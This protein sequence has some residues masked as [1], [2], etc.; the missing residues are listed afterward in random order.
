MP[1]HENTNMQEIKVELEAKVGE[2]SYS[3]LVI[4][5]HSDCEFIFDFATFLPGN[6]S[7][8]VHSRIIMTPKHAKLL[9]HSLQQNI[10]RFES[11]YGDIPVQHQESFMGGDGRPIVN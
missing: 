7:A 10:A 6:P 8:R 9:L 1:K 11:Q 5:A 4:I 3:N 2:G